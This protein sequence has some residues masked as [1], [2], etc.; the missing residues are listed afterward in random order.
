MLS[1]Q[2]SIDLFGKFEPRKE[3]SGSSGGDLEIHRDGR[4]VNN[5]DSPIFL[6]EVQNPGKDFT[7]KT[8][9]TATKFDFVFT[10]VFLMYIVFK[11]LHTEYMYCRL[12]QIQKE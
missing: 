12:F 4:A 9:S 11:V 1:D 3:T 8:S 2:L 6:N 5:L 7:N 10:R